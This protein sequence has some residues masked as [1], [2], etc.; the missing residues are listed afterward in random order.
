ML[1][2][3]YAGKKYHCGSLNTSHKFPFNS[4]QKLSMI[5]DLKLIYSNYAL[6]DMSY[7]VDKHWSKHAY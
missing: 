6:Q 4:G 7:P 3:V 5:N 2:G 1:V